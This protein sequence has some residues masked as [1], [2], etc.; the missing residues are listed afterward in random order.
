MRRTFR[1][2][3]A[4]R[5]AH[6]VL[7][8]L[9]GALSFGCGD[10]APSAA[11]PDRQVG[12]ASPADATRA[13]GGV[14]SL[15]GMPEIRFDGPLSP[16]AADDVTARLHWT[17]TNA[18]SCFGI[19]APS[20]VTGWTQAWPSVTTASDGFLVGALPRHATEA[21]HYDFTLRC[22]GEQDAIDGEPVVA[23]RDKTHRVTLLPGE[24][25]GGWTTC[26]GY[27]ASLSPSERA[28]FDA[29]RA[30]PRGFTAVTTSFTAHTGDV[31][32]VHMGVMGTRG[33]PLI[34]GKLDDHEY[35]AM[36]FSLPEGDPSNTGKFS[37]VT[38]RVTAHVP[39][40]EHELLLA[41]S[42]CPGDFRPRD[43]DAEDP[44]LH[45]SCRSQYTSTPNVRGSISLPDWC[46]IPPGQTMYLNIALRDLYR[47]P[48]EVIPADYCDPNV[49]YCG[50]GALISN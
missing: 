2:S 22:Y 48:G 5:R 28:H 49:S 13:D 4:S 38:Q 45:G 43:P 39:A 27:I 8:A 11:G 7:L 25:P 24:E 23:Y 30:E 17:A 50:M 47:A 42:P 6:L 19:A 14:G 3:G 31:L 36:T 21:S 29:Y 34:P 1:R 35:A 46:P 18:Q 41:I 37:L 44:Y 9:G 10:D 40:R 20:G 16:V 32:G 15:E 12:D 26:E 33:V